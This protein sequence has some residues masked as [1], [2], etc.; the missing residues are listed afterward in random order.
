MSALVL[1]PGALY[2]VGLVRSRS[3]KTALRRL[4]GAV[5][6]SVSGDR[7]TGTHE[8]VQVDC[9]YRPRKQGF[10]LASGLTSG[11]T[12]T[13]KSY[14]PGFFRVTRERAVD[15]LSKS[16]GLAREIETGDS[17]F[18]RD[19]Y[20]WGD[21]EFVGSVFASPEKRN[22]VRELFSLGATELE[23]DEGFT[24]AG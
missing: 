11:L 17:S 4:A 7:V 8:G 22:T 6:G 13:V 19:F 9:V 2:G 16:T 24:T 3:K 1:G 5:G 14:S 23:H 10:T 18:D 20:L 12:V 15:R 21:P